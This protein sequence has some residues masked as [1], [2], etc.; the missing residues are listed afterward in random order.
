MRPTHTA[1]AAPKRETAAS[2]R[3][4]GPPGGSLRPVETREFRCIMC[5]A[6]IVADDL[7][8][9]HPEAPEM[10]LLPEGVWFGFTRT[11]DDTTD[12]IVTCGQD[13]AQRL[14]IEE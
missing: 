10:M 7:N 9:P 8:S 11:D 2:R 3:P 12:L 6:P 1:R 5:E 13:C 4:G 14:L